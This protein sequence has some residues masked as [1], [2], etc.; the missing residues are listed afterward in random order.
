MRILF[1]THYYEPDSG[2]AAV[3]LSRL[4]KLLSQMGHEVTVLT[5]MPHYPQGKISD[6]YRNKF[7][8]DET[9]DGIRI[10]QVWLWATPN[11]S[12]FK[13]F[14]SQISFMITGFLRG[15]FLDRPDIV[16]IENQPIFTGIAGRMLADLKRAPYVLNVSDL[17]PDHLLTVGALSEQSIIYKLARSVVDAGYRGAERIVTLSPGWTTKLE[18]Q[19]AF[20]KPKLFTQLNGVDIDTFRPLPASDLDSF[21]SKYDIDKSKQWVTFLGTFST[22]YDF[23]LMLDVAKHFLDDDTVGF[24][25]V[26]TG[27]QEPLV[28]ERIEQDNLSNIKRIEWIEYSEMPLAW[29]ISTVNYWALRGEGLYTGTIPAKLFELLGCGIPIAAAQDS[30]ASDIIVNAEAGL[31]VKAGDTQGLIEHIERLLSDAELRSSLSQNGR[32]YAVEHLDYRKVAENYEKILLSSA[33]K[34]ASDIIETG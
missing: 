7:S 25:Y 30:I 29:N 20:V 33:K 12:I 31:V 19:Q 9:Q 5:T 32:A 6:A 13:R 10:V 4:A 24:L 16:F 21:Y 3:R 11:K 23:N 27:T 26:G 28:A 2:A 14:I 17:W 1:I 8:T 18:E 15:M 34:N 22:P